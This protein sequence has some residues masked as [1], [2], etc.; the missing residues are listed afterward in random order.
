MSKGPTKIEYAFCSCQGCEFLKSEMLI[1]GR[2]PEYTYRC[3]HPN[4]LSD[5]IEMFSVAEQIQTPDWC[6]FLNKETA[7]EEEK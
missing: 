1:S 5:F 7:D 4:R 6:P 2:N 3:L